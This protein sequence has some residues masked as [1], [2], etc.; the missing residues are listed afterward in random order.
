MTTKHRKPKRERKEDRIIIRVTEEQK[1]TL[2]Q[3]A[4]RTG[5]GVSPWLLVLGL[6]AADPREAR[7]IADDPERDCLGLAV[8]GR[9]RGYEP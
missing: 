2:T 1:I 6:S 8:H 4:T 3:A 7:P 9:M 5:L